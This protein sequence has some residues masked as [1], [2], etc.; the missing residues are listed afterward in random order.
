MGLVAHLRVRSPWSGIRLTSL[1]L[2]GEF[3]TNELPGKSS[4]YHSYRNHIPIP[5]L[6][7][8]TEWLNCVSNDKTASEKLGR[9]LK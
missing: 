3:P 1:A 2:A 5:I 8:E 9:L 4:S 6:D 7:L